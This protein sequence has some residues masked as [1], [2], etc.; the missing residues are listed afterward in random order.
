MHYTLLEIIQRVLSAMGADNVNSIDGTAESTAV[1][2]I[3]EEV[4][5]DLLATTDWPHLE[6]TGK[7]GSSNDMY[8]PNLLKLPKDVKYIKALWY[9]NKLLTYKEP[10]EFIKYVNQRQVGDN[11]YTVS[12][13]DGADLLIMDNKD[14]EFFTLFNSTDVITDSYDGEDY[15][16]LIGDSSLY[17]GNTL[18][19]FQ[20]VDSFVPDLPSEA[21]STY[22]AMV[23]RAAFMYLRQEPSPHDERVAVAGLG[24]IMQDKYK[25]YRKETKIN[26]GRK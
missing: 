23:K 16:T 11:T 19:V 17:T 6:S 15:S 24:R 18:P 3:A 25:L 26:Y 21:F 10:E 8:F 1:A 5:Y 7:L 20:P 12:T 14:P 4:Y 9:K 2:R 22:L 13:P